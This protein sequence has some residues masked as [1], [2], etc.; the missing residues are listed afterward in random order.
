MSTRFWGANR[1][2][3]LAAR[4]SV[5]HCHPMPRSPLRT[6][7]YAAEGVEDRS[8]GRVARGG[9][10]RD[11]ERAGRRAQA[12]Q[13]RA[14]VL[15]EAASFDLDLLDGVFEGLR[16]R[17]PASGL[18]R[19]THERQELLVPESLGGLGSDRMFL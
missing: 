5:W 2:I 6:R 11:A 19:L 3:P 10:H 18:D 15:G 14:L 16:G 7:F 1:G 9:R 17:G 4:Q 12:A 8:D 13:P